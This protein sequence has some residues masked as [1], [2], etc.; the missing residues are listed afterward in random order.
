MDATNY[1]EKLTQLE[2][3][4][5]R[6]PPGY[7]YRL[8]TEAEWEISARAGTTTAYYFGDDFGSISTFEWADTGQY[9]VKPVGLKQPNPWGIFDMLGNNPEWCSDWYAPYPLWEVSDPTGPTD[10]QARVVRGT[11]GAD[12]RHADYRCAARSEHLPSEQGL[13]FRIVLAPVQ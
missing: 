8:P 7:H 1:C 12:P 6:I 4:A 10:G 11:N 13:S 5:G 2:A 9:G 3:D